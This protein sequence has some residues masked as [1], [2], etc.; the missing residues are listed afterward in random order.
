MQIL[1]RS[2]G[3]GKSGKEELL[4]IVWQEHGQERELKCC[5]PPS[6]AYDFD[7]GLTEALELHRW[8]DNLQVFMQSDKSAS[9]MIEEMTTLT[10]MPSK[11]LEQVLRYAL[12]AWRQAES[13][14]DSELLAS[15]DEAVTMSLTDGLPTVS[16]ERHGSIKAAALQVI[17]TGGADSSILAMVRRGCAYEQ[18]EELL[19]P[20]GFNKAKAKVFYTVVSEFVR[21]ERAAAFEIV[22]TTGDSGVSVE[23]KA[24]G[25][26]LAS[27]AIFSTLADDVR[28]T[29]AAAFSTCCFEAG[30]KIFLQGDTGDAMYLIVRGD[31]EVVKEATSSSAEK[32][33]AVL[34]AGHC[35]GEMSLL[36]AEVRSAS[37][38]CRNATVCC[39]LRIEAFHELVAAYP[40]LKAAMVDVASE[41]AAFS[42][43][44][45]SRALSNLSGK[46]GAPQAKP[47][48]AAPAPAKVAPAPHGPRI[49]SAAQMDIVQ[50]KGIIDKCELLEAQLDQAVLDENYEEVA[51]ISKAI[52]GEA[53]QREV[54][55]C[56]VDGAQQ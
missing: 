35:F 12:L 6:G 39:V 13:A 16:S 46:A 25:K 43:R 37:M 11:V 20:L 22:E 32:V 10:Q 3:G 47:V 50:A 51:R 28:D 23:V 19:S 34:S 54:A 18:V 48:T 9:S 45:T 52:E 1:L 31:V 53:T 15:A 38:R 49:A 5:E 40:D 24:Q 30:A 21:K 44:A 36:S 7:K 41:R 4:H 27:V 42:S 17:K 26:G 33:V 8:H 29:V 56:V 55:Q 14:A 2:E